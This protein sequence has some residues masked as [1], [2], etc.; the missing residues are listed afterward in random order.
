M[1]KTIR[2]HFD[3]TRVL[4][5]DSE[6]NVDIA[7]KYGDIASPSTTSMRVTSR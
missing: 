4:V 3:V 7:D 1:P 6:A 2:G 5:V